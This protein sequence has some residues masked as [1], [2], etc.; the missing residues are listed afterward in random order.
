M[1]V[2]QARD[3]LLAAV[4]AEVEY[5]RRPFSVTNALSE[6]IDRMATWLTGDSSKFA[7]VLCGGC[8]NGKTTFVKAFQNMLSYLNIP[9]PDGHGKTYGMRIC[10]AREVAGVARTDYPAFLTLTRI[11]MLAIDDVGIEPLEVIEYGNAVSRVADQTLR[12]ATVYYYD[13]QSHTRRYP[14]AL[15]RPDCR[16]AQRDGDSH[17][18]QESFL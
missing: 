7:A 16:P 17:T 15:R 2:A 12:R 9:V 6:Q 14:Q 3:A 5:R 10:N 11:P 4:Q 8:G 18:L 1:N 13:H